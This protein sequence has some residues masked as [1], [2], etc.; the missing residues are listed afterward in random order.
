[1]RKTILCIDDDRNTA[2][3]IA[4]ELADRRFEVDTAYDGLEG[5]LAIMQSGPDLILCDTGV[6]M[7]SGFEVLE[8]FNEFVPDPGRVP[9]ILLSGQPDRDSE[10]KGRWL[11]A[12]DYVR[13]PIDFERLALIIDARILGIARTRQSARLAKINDR[14]VEVLTWVA[15][16]KTSA[17][18]AG[19]LSRSKRTVEFHIDNARVKLRAA[20]RTEA[21]IKAITGGLIHP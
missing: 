6:P 14:E 10:L 15:R 21:V 16:G 17:E 20:T 12:D 13:K 1:V 11:G 4:E 3:L 7:M 5:L 2:T 18:I 19:E 9:F 8:R